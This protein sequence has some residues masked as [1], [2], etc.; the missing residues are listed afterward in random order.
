MTTDTL[1][2]VIFDGIRFLE[3]LTRHYGPEKG[4]E[5]WEAIGSAAGKEVKGKV[6]FAMLTGYT[7][8][9]IRMSAGS[10]VAA[11]AVQVIKCIRTH[12]G[13][14]LKEAKDLWDSSKGTA[15][16]IEVAPDKQRQFSL[17]LKN[18][19]CIVS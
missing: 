19:G 3:S 16:T 2:E 8:G 4:M 18:L 11:N 15:I 10:A 13:L 6:F 7:N 1:D 12:T 5:V 9:K 14:G 17:D